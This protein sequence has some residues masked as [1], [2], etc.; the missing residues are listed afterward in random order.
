M[1]PVIVPGAWSL[2]HEIQNEC[3]VVIRLFLPV[4]DNGRKKQHTLLTS[5]LSVVLINSFVILME[6]NIIKLHGLNN[7]IWKLIGKGEGLGDTY[8]TMD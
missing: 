6:C 7:S 5:L 3:E 2:G 1:V 4:I 8:L